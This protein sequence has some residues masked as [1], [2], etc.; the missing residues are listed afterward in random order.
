M[1]L[2]NFK[3]ICKI[4]LLECL[5]TVTP[6]KDQM[7]FKLS[8]HVIKRID[9]REISEEIINQVLQSPDQKVP[10]KQ[11]ETIYQSKIEFDQKLYLVKL[12]VIETKNPAIVKT[13]YKTSK[14][15]KYW[16]E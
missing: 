7:D 11:E 13:I 3:L 8:Q 15:K 16:N 4:I 6:V 10:G 1:S 14:I 2:D 5:L 12:T 9:D